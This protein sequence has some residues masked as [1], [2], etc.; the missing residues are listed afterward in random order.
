MRKSIVLLVA[1]LASSP[2]FAQTQ[3][4]QVPAPMRTFETVTL[5]EG[6]YAFVS[7]ESNGAMV[8]GNSL[9][10]IGE[11]GVLV[12]DSGHFP[13][14]TAKQIAQ[15][16]Q[17]TDKPVRWL[18]NTHWHPDHNA[19]NGLYLKAWP[20][21]Q[22]VSTAATRD[23]IMNVLPKKEVNEAQIEE[24][25]GIAKKGTYPDGKPLS[26]DDKRYFDM[27]AVELEAFRP[28]L[29]AGEHVAPTTTFKDEISVWLGKR[30][31]RVLFLGRGNTAGDAVV[32]VPDAKLVASGDLVVYPVPYPFGSFIGEWIGT[33]KKLDALDATTILPG[34]GPVLR[35]HEYLKKNIALLEETMKQTEV[36]CK[37]P[38]MTA[39]EAVKHVDVSALR[40]GF[41]GDNKDRGYFFDNGFLRTAVVRACREAKEGPLKDEN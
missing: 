35:D 1:L 16:K 13:T 19:G 36:Q 33:L 32:Y 23:G 28:E 8:T 21:M 40:P 30:E 7:P 3:A 10:V 11:D 14:V 17:W 37:Q 6:V 15:I 24:M 2:A 4:L 9:V 25:T 5:A 29:K 18:V 22:I 34:H 27:V 41:V 12:V 38:G 20:G 26:E 39:N 31:V